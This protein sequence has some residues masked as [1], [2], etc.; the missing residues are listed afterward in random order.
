MIEAKRNHT[1]DDVVAMQLDVLVPEAQMVLDLMIQ[2]VD[3]TGLSSFEQSV[4]DRLQRWDRKATID[5]PE[6]TI[7]I[8]WNQKVETFLF[9]SD[10]KTVGKIPLRDTPVRLPVDALWR[11]LR[12]EVS[13]AGGLVTALHDG[14]EAAL[15]QLERDLGK[16]DAVLS[17]WAWGDYHPMTVQALDGNADWNM[18]P[19]PS[20]GT[21]NTVSMAKEEG[22]GPYTGGTAASFRLVVE[23]GDEVRAAGVLPGQSRDVPTSTYPDGVNLWRQGELRDFRFNPSDIAAHTSTEQELVW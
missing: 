1:F 18:E 11:A 19:F 17:N 3:L 2:R 6:T 22:T 4:I 14:L 9:G 21:R 12:G 13:H 7:F 23:L 20:P 8:L 5:S 15:T 10:L 16:P